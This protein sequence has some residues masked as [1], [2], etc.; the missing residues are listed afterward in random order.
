MVP[1]EVTTWVMGVAL[2]VGL[3]GSGLGLRWVARLP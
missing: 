2:L 3:L 1:V